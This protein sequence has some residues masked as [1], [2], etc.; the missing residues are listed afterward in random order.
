MSREENLAKVQAGP[1]NF[2]ECLVGGGA[3]EQARRKKI[4]RSAIAVS[5]TLQTLALGAL[6]I[7]PMLAKPAEI[8]T[9]TAMPIPPYGH[10]PQRQPQRTTQPIPHR[11]LADNYLHLAPIEQIISHPPGATDPGP[12]APT[13][14]GA[15]SILGS[16]SQIPIAD[17]RGPER[18][19]EPPKQTTRLH[20]SSVDPAMLVRRVEPV[21]PPLARQIR[22]SGKVELHAIIATEGS[23][24]SLEVVS[25]DPM[26]IQSAL[27]AVRQWRYRPTML[28]GQ[29]VE[30]DT[31]I[32]VVYTVNQP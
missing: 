20:R 16:A 8:K 23:I 3:E 13:I 6:V 5:V 30:I 4:K 14:P 29:P 32:T 24:Q 21:F 7:A 27:D 31:F 11:H 18:P 2:G 25:G 17:S 22:R 10:P 26:F 15:T 19:V 9:V 1:G 28:N 12:E